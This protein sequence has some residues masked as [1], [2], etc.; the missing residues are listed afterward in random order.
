MKDSSVEW[1]NSAA[2]YAAGSDDSLSHKLTQRATRL[3]ESGAE[4]QSCSVE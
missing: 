1:S 2:E 3:H 4:E